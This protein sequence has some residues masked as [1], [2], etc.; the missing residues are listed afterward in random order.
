MFNKLIRYY[1]QNRK[2]IWRII[3]ICA[4]IIIMIRLANYIAGLDIKNK[5]ETTYDNKEEKLQT[6]SIISD[7]KIS[8]KTAISNNQA[9]EEFVGFCN[10][11]KIESA[12]AM[13]TEDCKNALYETVDV[14]KE[15]Y[16]NKIFATKKLYTK[17]NWYSDNGVV[18]YRVTYTNNLLADGG[19]K[20]EESF[21]DYITVIKDNDQY[22]LNIGQFIDGEELNKTYEDDNIKIEVISRQTFRL[23]E[24]YQI[25]FYNKTQSTINLYDTQI[26]SDSKWYIIDK[27]S[28]KSNAAISEV[29]GSYLN[30]EANRNQTINVKFTKTYNPDKK[31]NKIT[32]ENIRI[33]NDTTSIEIKL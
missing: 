32:F 4:F 3:G 14:F 9:I 8:E 10:D 11:G 28:K 6:E 33:G 29:P 12:Y 23:Y 22:K 17:E 7:T 18:T 26:N 19:V 16:Y 13:L 27:D 31:T 20:S 15:L 21:G 25:E 2:M 24:I 5:Q 30:I 1:N